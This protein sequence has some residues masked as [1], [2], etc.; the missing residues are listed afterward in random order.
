MHLLG[1]VKTIE[2]LL[3]AKVLA[4]RGDG[5]VY[6]GGAVDPAEAFDDLLAEHRSG[7]FRGTSGLV[8]TE[9]VVNGYPAAVRHAL[10]VILQLGGVPSVADAQSAEWALHLGFRARAATYLGWAIEPDLAVT[11]LERRGPFAPSWWT[12]SWAPGWT[13]IGLR[14]PMPSS[15]GLTPVLPQPLTE[16]RGIIATDPADVGIAICAAVLNLPCILAASHPNGKTDARAFAAPV[17]WARQAG[18][19]NNVAWSLEEAQGLAKLGVRPVSRERVWEQREVALAEVARLAES[20]DPIVQALGNCGLEAR[21]NP[22]AEMP[23]VARPRELK[24]GSL[25]SPE[26]HYDAGYYGGEAGI[27]Y[28]LP[29][30][31]QAVYTA[32]G[33]DWGGFEPIARW[34]APLVGGKLLDIGCGSGPFV[35][36][37]LKQQVDAYGVDISADAIHMSPDLADER[38]WQGDIVN[39]DPLWTTD[40]FVTVVSA[41]DLLEHIPAS[42]V[43]A[44]LQRIREALVMGGLVFANICTRG[45]GEP[46]WTIEPPCVV[47]QENSWLLVSGHITIREWEWWACRFAD[48]GLTPRN[49]LMQSFNVMKA[50][51]PGLAPV[52]SWSPRNVLIAERTR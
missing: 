24:V 33:H 17:R 32:T 22:T 20:A 44:L 49:G 36:A 47:T 25:W 29:D 7:T 3:A 10:G 52:A 42:K 34:L 35:R 31:S 38:I 12:A 37:M 13:F 21:R 26:T 41:L 8:I 9:D 43:D 51:D 14:S 28:T 39:G 16:L 48:A 15:W 46:D 30:G 27:R 45:A 18:V 11:V 4:R 40:L 2:R 19:E 23:V 50:S 5:A 6:G 1:E